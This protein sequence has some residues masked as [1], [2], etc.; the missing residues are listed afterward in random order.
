MPLLLVHPTDFEVQ[1]AA[2]A[3]V[4]RFKRDDTFIKVRRLPQA[5][6]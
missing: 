3:F 1:R 2:V 6:Q 4:K 5:W